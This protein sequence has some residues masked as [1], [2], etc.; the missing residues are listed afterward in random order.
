MIEELY[1]A[2]KPILPDHLARWEEKAGD[3]RSALNTLVNYAKSRPKRMLQFL[4][5]AERLHLTKA[6]MQTYFGD[7]MALVGVNYDEIKKP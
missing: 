2:M 4:K 3:Y 5:Y 1:N 7:A 6:E